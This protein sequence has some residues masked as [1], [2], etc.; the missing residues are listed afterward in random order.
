M[1][2]RLTELGIYALEAGCIAVHWIGVGWVAFTQA[3]ALMI[4]DIDSYRKLGGR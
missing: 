1:I 2:D 3:I 4:G